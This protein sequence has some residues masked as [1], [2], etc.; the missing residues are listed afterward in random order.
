MIMNEMQNVTSLTL[1]EGSWGTENVSS[2]DV[3]IPKL[4]LM[5]GLSEL[6][7]QEKAKAGDIVNSVTGIV[8]GG[9]T[10]PVEM[11]PITTWRTLITMEEINGKMEYKT[12]EPLTAANEILP[13]EE[14]V[15]GVKVRRVKSLNF[16]VLLTSELT[17]PGALPYLLSFRS[18]SYTTGRKLI[19]HFIQADRMKIPPAKA[20]FN[21]LC[22]QEKNDKG[23]YYVFDLAFSR[24]TTESELLTA[25]E[26]YVTMRGPNNY[27]S[28]EK[29]DDIEKVTETTKF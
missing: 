23:P 7:A 11:I 5:Q 12:Q 2:S 1:P 16:Y 29:L 15:N 9:K 3:L 28:D 6:V 13:W 27:R 21:L 25:Y 14:V 18:T 20:A 26:W 8:V 17:V 22:H 10:T 19:N 24:S 4:L